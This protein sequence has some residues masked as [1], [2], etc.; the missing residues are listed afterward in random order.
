MGYLFVDDD[1][2][3]IGISN[4]EEFSVMN[5]CDNELSGVYIIK[6]QSVS[7]FRTSVH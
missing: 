5:N 6:L 4:L 2:I 3:R 1:A 7:S